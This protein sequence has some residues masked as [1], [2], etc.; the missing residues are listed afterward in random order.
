MATLILVPAYMDYATEIAVKH[1]WDIGQD[2]IV[3]T[4]GVR[5]TYASIHDMDAIKKDFDLVYIRYHGGAEIA[6]VY[7]KA[8]DN[9]R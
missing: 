6:V 9:D 7:E 4:I 8:A 2:F 1:A 3:S 5:G